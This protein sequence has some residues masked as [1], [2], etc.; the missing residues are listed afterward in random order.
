MLA[1]SAFNKFF[2]FRNK[3]VFFEGAIDVLKALSERYK[4]YALTNGN[5]DVKVIGIDKF[6]SGAVSSADVG[7]SK[8][9]P[10]I[11]EATLKKAGE[12]ASSCIHI[13]DD[14]EDDIVGANNAGIASIWLNE[15]GQKDPSMNLATKVVTKVK[16]IPHAVKMIAE[17]K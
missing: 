16:E 17:P 14:Y 15:R 10:K 7:V 1:N 3:V 6:L 12:E 4:V 9:N 11:F 2:E 13:G 8:P 5:A